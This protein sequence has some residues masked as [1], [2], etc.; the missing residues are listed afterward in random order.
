[1][2]WSSGTCFVVNR[3]LRIDHWNDAMTDFMG[4]PEAE[5][6]HQKCFDVFQ[7]R[8]FTGLNF[9]QMPCPLLATPQSET[10]EP[11]I[12]VVPTRF[13]GQRLVQIHFALWENPLTI[14]H[15]IHPLNRDFTPATPLTPRQ[16]QIFSL[17]SQGKT[18]PEIAH[19]LAITLSTVNTHIRRVCDLW[20]VGTERQ[21]LTYFMRIQ[22]AGHSPPNRDHDSN[23]T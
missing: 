15:W 8:S 17:L 1:M 12:I 19:S 18:R 10:E 20:D 14:V 2:I 4:I 21:A 3:Q 11:V 6:L 22:S 23:T 9:C 13:T 16:H 5:A 7:S